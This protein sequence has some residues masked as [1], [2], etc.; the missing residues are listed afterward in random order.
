MGQCKK[1]WW[2]WPKWIRRWTVIPDHSGSTPLRHPKFK[3]SDKIM[4]R[5]KLALVLGIIILTADLVSGFGDL[6]FYFKTNE[7]RF[8]Y[9][10]IVAFVISV[11]LSFCLQKLSNALRGLRVQQEKL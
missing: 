7:A 5:G 4:K 9:L 1:L 10:G 3:P 11:G 2:R 6:V 8:L